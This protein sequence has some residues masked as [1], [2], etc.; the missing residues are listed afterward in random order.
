MAQENVVYYNPIEELDEDLDINIE[1]LWKT[2]WSRKEL[3]I[4]V[5]CSGCC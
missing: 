4:K 5:F 3:L 1:K 2:I